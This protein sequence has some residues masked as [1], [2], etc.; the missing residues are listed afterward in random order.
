MAHVGQVLLRQIVFNHGRRIP[1]QPLGSVRNWLPLLP[2]T[3]VSNA[4]EKCTV[5]LPRPGDGWYAPPPSS[6]GPGDGSSGFPWGELTTAGVE[7]M[8]VAG[9]RLFD[10]VGPEPWARSRVLMRSANT[11]SSIA[12]AQALVVG[13]QQATLEAAE[14]DADSSRSKPV[15]V[16]VILQQGEDL[17]P[18]VAPESS[19]FP[20]LL[21]HASAQMSTVEKAMR[22][23]FVE[24]AQGLEKKLGIPPNTCNVLGLQESSAGNTDCFRNL[25]WASLYEV[26]MAVERCSPSSSNDSALILSQHQLDALRRFAFFRWTA[27]LSTAA[28]DP[29]MV[30]NAEAVI[31]PM[32]RALLQEC[33]KAWDDRANIGSSSPG[34]STEM[35]R[36]SNELVIYNSQAGV[37]VSLLAV[38]GNLAHVSDSAP[39]SLSFGSPDGPLW[40]DFGA[41]LELALVQVDGEPFLRCSSDG[42]SLIPG[43]ELISYRLIR[44]KLTLSSIEDE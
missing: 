11:P 13:L 26:L 29:N 16:E 39:A 25:R 33:D 18:C 22:E 6:D 21:D 5:V 28:N 2:D 9:R 12:S 40:P 14:Q 38:L 1:S 41:S 23:I 30:P 8:Q 27:P 24:A 37:L 15:P 17:M 31:G 35:N 43:M 44:E 32:L 19:A 4:M 20:E 42:I 34:I 36:S 10:Q 7:E 3:S